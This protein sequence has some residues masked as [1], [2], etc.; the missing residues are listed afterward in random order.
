MDVDGRWGLHGQRWVGARAGRGNRL[1]RS[2]QSERL[3]RLG[4]YRQGPA[5]G[6]RVWADGCQAMDGWVRDSGRWAPAVQLCPTYLHRARMARGGDLARMRRAPAVCHL[7]SSYICRSDAMEGVV[8]TRDGSG[9]AQATHT[10]SNHSSHHTNGRCIS[11]Q[12]CRL[13]STTASPTRDE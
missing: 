5:I 7:A 4:R 10:T 6:Y 1:E 3:E 9:W 11:Q 2:S 13:A 12:S 8:Q